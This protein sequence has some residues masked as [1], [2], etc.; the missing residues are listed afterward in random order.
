MTGFL[1]QL[2]NT[3]PPSSIFKPWTKFSNLFIVQI[4]FVSDSFHVEMECDKALLKFPCTFF[5]LKVIFL[6]KGSDGC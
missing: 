4:T 5:H 3:N 1:S 6:L 2:L